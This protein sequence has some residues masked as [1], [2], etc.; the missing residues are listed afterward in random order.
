VHADNMPQTYLQETT[1]EGHIQTRLSPTHLLHKAFVQPLHVVSRAQ[2]HL[3]TPA[4]AHGLLCSSDRELAYAQLVDS[5][6]LRCQ[7]E[8]V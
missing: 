7:I 2:T 8:I 3:R 1:V 4:Q 5:D 6:S